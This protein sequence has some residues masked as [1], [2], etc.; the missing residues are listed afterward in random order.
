[1]IPIMRAA[2]STGI[3]LT[4]FMATCLKRRVNLLP[5]LAQGTVVRLRH[6]QGSKREEPLPLYSSDAEESSG[7]SR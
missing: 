1:M 5:F 4:M 2:A 7:A 6:A 3:S